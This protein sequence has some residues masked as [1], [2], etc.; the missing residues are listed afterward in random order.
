MEKELTKKWAG[1]SLTDR[2]K[3]KKEMILSSSILDKAKAQGRSCM[4]A[5]IIADKI[6]NI[7]AFKSTISR[8]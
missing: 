2:K 3:K 8:I 5:M 7:E 1:L 6:V 4:F